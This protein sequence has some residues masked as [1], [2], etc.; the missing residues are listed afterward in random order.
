LSNRRRADGSRVAAT[1]DEM[2]ERLQAGHPQAI[3]VRRIQTGEKP[4]RI[5]KD[6]GIA[7][8]TVYRW[9]DLVA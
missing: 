6:M 7:N 1:F 2:A 3:A 5:A 4:N 8:S 9:R